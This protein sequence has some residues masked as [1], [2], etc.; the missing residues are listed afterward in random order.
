[1]EIRRIDRYRILIPRTGAMRVDGLVFADEELFNEFT[2]PEALQQV[3]NVAH[4]PGIVGYALAMPDIHWGYGF[5]IGGVGATDV[6]AGGVISPGGVGFDINC[7]VRLLRT[8][9]RFDEVK[10]KIDKIMA[11][12]Y[13]EVPA[14]LGSESEKNLSKKQLRKVLEEGAGWVVRQGWG[15][16]ED[17]EYCEENGVMFDAN[18]DRISDRAYER[19]K[20]QLGTLGS[21]NHFLEV[22]VVEEI[23]APEVARVFGLFSGQITVMLHSGSR[24]FGHQ[25]CSDYIKVMLK[26]MDKYGIK[27]PDKQLACAPFYCE[28]GQA[29]WEAMCCAANYAWANRQMM[30]HLVRGAFQKSLGISPKELGMKLVYDVAH[31]I[32]KLERHRVGEKFRTLCVHRK[33]ATRAFGPGREELPESYK[34]VGQPVIIPGDMGRCSYVL[35]GTKQAMEE[36]FGSSCHGA[37]RVKSRSK[38]LKEIDYG[39]LVKSLKEKGIVAYSHGK[40]TLVEEAPEV[41]K[42]VSKVVEVMH[43]AGITLK[44]ARMR[45]LGVIKG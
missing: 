5:P 23:F 14:G 29:Y 41:Y 34:K 43:G 10:D 40:R 27:V 32:A 38:A 7:G 12:L 4:L 11:C 37:G 39:H 28:E 19:G 22:Q 42:D 45:P 31:N 24:G 30:T 18:P 9:L 1:M 21:G 44:V 6:D 33:G 15:V 16:S 36:T 17:L 25:V 35:V 3:V 2:E 20:E 26:A 8:N 13:S